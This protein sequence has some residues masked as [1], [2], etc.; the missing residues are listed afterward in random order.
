MIANPNNLVWMDLEMTGLEPDHDIII[1]IA[2]I[3]TDGE[4]NIL[5]EGPNIV[6]HQPDE[7]LQAMDEWNTTHHGESGLTAKVRASQV[8]MAEAEQVTLDFIR[9]YVPEGSSPLCG[10]SIHQDRRFLVRYMQKLEAYV[11]YRNIDVSTIKELARRWYPEDKAPIKQ[12]EHQA[13]SDVRESINE[14]IWY[15]THLFR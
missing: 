2:T 9:R 13:L 1:E 6:I 11:H 4:L 8:S 14:L 12:A 7:A 15:R 5:A 10:N 3:I